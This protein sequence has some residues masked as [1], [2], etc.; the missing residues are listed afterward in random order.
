LLQN[1]LLLFCPRATEV[2][3]FFHHGFDPADYS[4]FSD[5]CLKKSC[6]YEEATINTAIAWN[7][8]KRRNAQ[9]FNDAVESLSF[10]TRRC[11]QDI[12]L[13][14]FRCNSPSS[15]SF[16]NSWCNGYDPP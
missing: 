4:N 7:I 3:D 10:V 5:L 14:A 12:K 13:W 8:W 2:W 6:S 11:I 1:L 9:T 15:T 16:L